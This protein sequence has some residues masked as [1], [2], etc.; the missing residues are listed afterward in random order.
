MERLPN[1]VY[2]FLDF[3]VC[4]A[5]FFLFQADYV[6]T[7]RPVRG[8]WLRFPDGMLPSDYF[9]QNV[10]LSFQEDRVG[11]RVRDVV[12]GVGRGGRDGR[13]GPRAPRLREP[14]PPR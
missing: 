11:M 7:D 3:L 9:K 10:F 13:K 5:P 6:Y 4:W 8:D 1:N 14:D 12:G 2:Q